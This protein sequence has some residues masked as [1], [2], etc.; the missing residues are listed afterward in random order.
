MNA[1]SLK[2]IF[3]QKISVMKTKL[4]LLAFALLAIF[5]TACEGPDAELDKAAV[6]QIVNETLAAQQAGQKDGILIQVTA[7]PDN[8]HRV[9]MPLQ[10]AA[11]M[12]ESQDVIMY[13]DIDAVK[14]VVKDA[15]D[16]T[17][18]QFPS[19][20]TQLKQL[21]E[22]GVPL[23]ACPGCLQAAGYKPEDLMEGLQ[24]AEKDKFFSFTKGRIVTLDY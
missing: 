11:M 15:P 18:A 9:L 16:L 3:N 13:F 2:E 1:V 6:Q 10:M 5:L 14:V 8:P 20:K 21:L 24:I 7:G 19:S 22:K 23:Y 12:S 17:Y 4:I